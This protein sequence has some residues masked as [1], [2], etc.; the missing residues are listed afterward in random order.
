MTQSRIMMGT[1][2]DMRV[3]GKSAEKAMEQAYA[4]IQEIENRMSVNLE[5]SEISQINKAAGLNPVKVSTETIAVLQKAIEFAQLTNGAFDPT[6]GPLVSAWGISTDH[7]RVPTVIEI[8]YLTDLINWQDVEIKAEENQVSLARP[9]MAIDLGAIA[10]GYA[11]DEAVAV[12]RA[13]G[14]E[15]AFVNL[16]G[17]VYVIG[18]KPDN[19][20]WRIGIRDPFAQEANSF[21]GVISATDTSV[22][23]SGTYE[24]YFVKN[25]VTYHHILDPKTGYPAES[26]LASVTIISPESIVADAVST[27]TFLIGKEA[28]KALI[29]SLPNV[30]AVLV[31]KDRNVWV[32]SGIR[33]Q[34]EIAEGFALDETR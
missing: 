23:T 3:Y 25:G 33:N 32:S 12:L 6:I 17:N 14:V 30:E 4:K 8:D 15:S 7:P 26:D 28:G 21:V 27:S 5:G 19:S 20:P 22:V 31:D 11:A 10:K 13:N 29:E 1:V 18:A 34:F 16:G 24:R 9:G 2:V